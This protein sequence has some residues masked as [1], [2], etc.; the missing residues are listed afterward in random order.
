MTKWIG[1]RKRKRLP[2]VPP[3]KGHTDPTEYLENYEGQMASKG[4]SNKAASYLLPHTRKGN[5]KA[6]FKSVPSESVSLW[7]QL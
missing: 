2:Q 7:K 5:A 6:S 4:I 1:W 3:Y